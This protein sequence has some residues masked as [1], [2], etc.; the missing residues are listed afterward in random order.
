MIQPL[1]SPKP[2]R[3]DECL[4]CPSAPRGRKPSVTFDS[5]DIVVPLFFPISCSILS[6]NGS[7]AM[8]ENDDPG[9]INVPAADFSLKR[10]EYK[11]EAPR[12]LSIQDFPTL[13]FS[14]P[15]AS[16]N[17]QTPSSH[18]SSHTVARSR[19]DPKKLRPYIQQRRS[20]VDTFRAPRPSVDPKKLRPYIEQRRS[21][22]DHIECKRAT[23]NARCA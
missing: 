14:F 19:S 18:R 4:N 16:A 9:K 1:N 23:F 22:L 13:P 11:S 20:S 3:Y 21:S 2:R 7:T 12:K 5:R 15:A 6:T 10:R 17:D 8:K